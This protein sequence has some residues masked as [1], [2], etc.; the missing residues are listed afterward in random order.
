MPEYAILEQGQLQSFP[1]TRELEGRSQGVGFS[2]ILVDMPPGAGVRLHRHAYAEMFIVQ[3]GRAT[4][5][6]GA[7]SIELEAPR[8]V[9]VHSGV[10]HAFVNSGQGPLRQV[11]IHDSP[12]IVT[13]WLE[14]E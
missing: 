2:F 6:V 4:F 10:P 12:T 8:V 1:H 7:E 11:D 13:E 14:K 3:A 5:T 9:V